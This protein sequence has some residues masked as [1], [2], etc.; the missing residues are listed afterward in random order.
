MKITINTNMA[1]RANFVRIIYP[2]LNF[3]AQKVLNRSLSQA[4]YINLLNWHANPNNAD[5]VKY[6]IYMVEGEIKNLLIELNAITSQYW[7]RS[8]EKDKTYIYA[9]CAV[10]NED[11]EGDPTHITVQ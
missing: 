7:H 8:V 5:I 1:I 11:R 2:P 10:N 3:T 6:R 4:E 9:I